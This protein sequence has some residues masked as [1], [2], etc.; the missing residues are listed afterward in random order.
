MKEALISLL[1]VATNRRQCKT[2]RSL[3][4]AEASLKSNKTLLVDSQASLHPR[5]IKEFVSE[6]LELIYQQQTCCHLHKAKLSC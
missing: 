1:R 4:I 6:H 2:N 5:W 3:Q